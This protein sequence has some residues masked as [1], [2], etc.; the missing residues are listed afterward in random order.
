MRQESYKLIARLFESVLQEDS[1][2]MGVLGSIPGGQAVVK[3]LH[4]DMGLGHDLIYNEITKIS[5]SELKETYKGAWVLIKGEKGAGAIR[6]KS[7]SYESV[8]VDP[9]TGVVDTFRDDRG[10]NNIDFLKSHIGKLR[11]FYVTKETGKAA[12]VKRKRAELNKAVDPIKPITADTLIKR[13]QP[14]WALAISTAEADIKGMIVTMIKNGAYEKAQKKLKILKNLQDAVDSIEAGELANADIAP[15]WLKGAVK[16]AVYMAAAHH[17]PEE[18]GELRRDS[19]SG[20]LDAQNSKGSKMILS[21]I[22]GGDTAKLGTVL[23]FF[24]RN[25]IT[26]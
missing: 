10:G 25:L 14:V 13:F 6:A 3:K 23:G 24:K 15:T 19:Y 26:I 5:W 8:A 7:G 21:D 22:A 18:T 11:A 1:T 9:Q 4:Q 20:L 2:A 16:N 12:D 17:Y